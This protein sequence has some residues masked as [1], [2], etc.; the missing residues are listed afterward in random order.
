MGVQNNIAV[1][2]TISRVKLKIMSEGELN[3]MG[4]QNNIAVDYTISRVKLKIMSEIGPSISETYIAALAKV[5]GL[6]ET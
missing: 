1:D 2:Y 4:V 6:V 5:G 3:I